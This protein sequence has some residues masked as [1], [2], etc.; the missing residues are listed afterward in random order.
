MNAN[1]ILQILIGDVIFSAIISAVFVVISNRASAQERQQL[2]KEMLYLKDN[3]EQHFKAVERKIDALKE[4]TL[5]S[6]KTGDV[7]Q[8]L[9]LLQKAEKESPPHGQ[10]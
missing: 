8:F 4:M 2:E 5:E 6:G 7:L 3:L 10:S 9:Q 1:F